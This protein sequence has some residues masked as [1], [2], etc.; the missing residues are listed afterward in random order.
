MVSSKLRKGVNPMTEFIIEPMAAVGLRPNHLTL[1][2]LFTG[3]LAV[4]VFFT[5]SRVLGLALF[6]I[7]ALFDLFD[8]ALARRTKLVS[9]FGEYFDAVSDKIVESLL[10]FCFGVYDWRLAFL[11]GTSSILVSYS[12]HRADKFRIRVAHGLFERAERLVFVLISS[13]LAESFG[14]T[15]FIPFVL[16]VSITLSLIT[17]SQRISSVHKA[18]H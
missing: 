7:S 9:S 10:F 14:L 1:L 16:A 5:I 4:I 2:G 12:K 15:R 8:G 11:A 6:F 3:L 13:I 17:I 18:L